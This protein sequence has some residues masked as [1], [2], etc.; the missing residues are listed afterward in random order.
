MWRPEVDTGI[1]LSASLLYIDEGGGH[2][3]HLTWST[4]LDQLLASHRRSSVSSSLAL[5]LRVLTTISSGHMGLEL[6][7]LCFMNS[8][9]SQPLAFT[10]RVTQARHQH[11]RDFSYK[12]PSASVGRSGPCPVGIRHRPLGILKKLQVS[13]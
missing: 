13:P 5:R 7:S 9:I 12:V 6:G 4:G 3:S 11:S 10:E 1:V 8:L 2:V